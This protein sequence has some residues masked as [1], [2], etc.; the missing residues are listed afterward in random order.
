MNFRIR[1]KFI[2]ILVI[3]SLLP[4]GIALIFFRWFGERYSRQSEGIRYQEAA[5]HLSHSLTH[6][7]RSEIELFNLWRRLSGIATAVGASH[8]AQPQQSEAER[9]AAIEATEALWPT[10]TAES[11]QIQG[12]LQNNLSRQMQLF[13]AEHRNFAEIFITDREG[14]LI[15]ATQ[16]TSDYWAGRVRRWWRGGGAAG[17]GHGL[18]GGAEL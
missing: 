5:A 6:S 15:A 3:A 1:S 12:L 10:L 9:M 11:P 18:A 8:V 16:K 17:C 13:I 2:G 4:L 7:L 14:R